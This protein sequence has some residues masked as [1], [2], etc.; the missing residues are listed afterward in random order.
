MTSTVTLATEN[1][2]NTSM[3]ASLSLIV[4]VLLIMLLIQ[5][6]ILSG[7]RAAWAKR[8]RSAFNIALVPL[9]LILLTSFA[10]RVA[11]VLR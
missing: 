7:S 1:V 4:I 8:L 3:A 2:L 9:I 5:Q 10:L 11:A 6:E